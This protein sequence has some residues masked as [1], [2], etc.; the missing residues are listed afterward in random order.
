V[1][2]HKTSTYDFAD[3]TAHTVDTL[4]AVRALLARET[5]CKKYT[6][7]F[8]VTC[9]TAYLTGEK[10]VEPETRL[11][12]LALSTRT[13]WA[14]WEALT[15]TVDTGFAHFTVVTGR[16]RCAHH[17]GDFNNLVGK[18]LVGFLH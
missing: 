4:L 2:K 10:A 15:F 9:S 17:T 6:R 18:F 16:A 1:K 8:S 11:L 3:G 12:L 5:I 14:T 7:E 13:K